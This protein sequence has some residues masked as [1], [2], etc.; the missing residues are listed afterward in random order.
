VFC[1]R[2]GRGQE[3]VYYFIKKGGDSLNACQGCIVRMQ[4]GLP[5]SQ[6]GQSALLSLPMLLPEDGKLHSYI[7]HIAL[8]NSPH[9]S[10]LCLRVLNALDWK[11]K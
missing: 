2:G 10:T 3:R 8:L 11:V 9:L 6:G 5:A 4:D 7:Y 1:V